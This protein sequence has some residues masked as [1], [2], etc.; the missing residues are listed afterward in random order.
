MGRNQW[1]A[2]LDELCRSLQHCASN[3]PEAPRSS[4]TAVPLSSSLYLANSASDA[5]FS[6]ICATGYLSSA[7]RLGRSQSPKCPEVILGTAGSV[8]FY[9]S[10]F[11]YP[12]TG[13][14]LLFA[15]S[16][17]LQH[18][19]DGVA[20]PFDSGGLV[21]ILTRRDPNESPREFLSRHELPIP[22]HRRY[23]CRSMDA[24]F[25]KPEDYAEGS[26]P[27]WP[28]P[29]GLDGGNHRRWTHEV[30][31]PDRDP[32]RGSHLQAVF[33]P[34]ARVAASQNVEEIFQWCA[35]EG[36]DRISFDTPRGDDFEALR[37]ECLAYIRR[38][39]Y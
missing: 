37:R 39:L 11:R 15:N 5:N 9:V 28:G 17:E 18:E 32:V 10:P 25:N 4:A 34:K 30:R 16:M 20:T 19:N 36:V 38:K 33:A 6:A 24:L 7:A 22:D 14:G 26:H 21:S 13:C 8:F 12:N 31:I 23:L 27:R 29:I 35:T 1:K 2:N 3:L